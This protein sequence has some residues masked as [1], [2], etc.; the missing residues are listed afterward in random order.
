[1][2]I[3]R[4]AHTVHDDLDTVELHGR[5]AVEESLVEVELVDQA[6]AP[7]GLHRDP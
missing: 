6:G 5:V 2:S 1:L 4:D 3:V 7:A